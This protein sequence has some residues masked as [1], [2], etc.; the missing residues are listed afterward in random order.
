MS[1]PRI[2]PGAAERLLEPVQPYMPGFE[3]EQ[4][5]RDLSQFYTPAP[6]AARCWA[7]M[8]A[9]LDPHRARVLEPSAGR[10]ALINPLRA[11]PPE[12]IAQVV[13]YDVDPGNVEHLATLG[14]SMPFPVTVRA[15][16]FM[17]DDMLG[18]RFDAA[19]MN[20]PFEN[21]QDVAF[22]A[23]AC[24]VCTRVVAICQA[25]IVHS[26]GRAGFWRW[27]DPLREATLIERRRTRSGGE[28]C[29]EPA[30]P[31]ATS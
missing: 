8:Q 20:P 14:A 31:S 4:R 22:I 16:D 27:H 21:G 29:R 28:R 30:A 19:V 5:R 17:A 11:F 7:W 1:Q 15:R 23:R 13:A 24:G 10:G 2:T 12:W 18:E 3:S 25:R 6:L 9:E 26:A